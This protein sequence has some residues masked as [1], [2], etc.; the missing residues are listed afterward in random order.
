MKAK[1]EDCT[2]VNDWMLNVVNIDVSRVYYSADSIDY[3]EKSRE[4]LYQ[5]KLPNSFVIISFTAA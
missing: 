4:L 2:E 1:N 5:I 3:E